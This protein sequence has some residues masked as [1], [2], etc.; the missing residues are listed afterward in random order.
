M[1]AAI[2]CNVKGRPLFILSTIE[3][4]SHTWNLVYLQSVLEEHGIMVLNMGPCVPAEVTVSAMLMHRPDAVIV[5]SVN[6]HGYVQ[7]RTLLHLA[8]Q[9]FGKTFPPMV[10]GGKLSTCEAQNASIRRHLLQ[11]GFGAVFVGA[12]AIPEFQ[13]WLIHFYERRHEMAVPA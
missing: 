11:L 13:R 1:T 9:R 8:G 7:G 3:S 12:H 10:I 5:S 2:R 6:G 4:D